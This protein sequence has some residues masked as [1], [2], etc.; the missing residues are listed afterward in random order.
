M[1]KLVNEKHMV[2]L[3]PKLAAR[4][5]LNEAIILQHIHSKLK[6]SELHRDGRVW[7]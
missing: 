5:G 2:M 4:I 1:E 7:I 3:D 6:E